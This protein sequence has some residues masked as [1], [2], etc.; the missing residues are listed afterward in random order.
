MN[1]ATLLVFA[2]LLTLYGLAIRSVCRQGA[3][4]DCGARAV[5][6]AHQLRA[7]GLKKPDAAA[8]ANARRLSEQAGGPKLIIT[9]RKSD[10]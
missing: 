8:R 3:C 6:P 4:A 5:C 9:V 1:L 2:I 7:H 10:Q